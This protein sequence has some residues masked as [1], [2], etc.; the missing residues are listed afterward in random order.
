MCGEVLAYCLNFSPSLAPDLPAA[1]GC[2]ETGD[3]FCGLNGAA[4]Q[5]RIKSPGSP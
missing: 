5:K 3:A 1:G 2:L 4:R